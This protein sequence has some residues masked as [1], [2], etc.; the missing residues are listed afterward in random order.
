VK[1][2]NYFV[3]EKRDP[4]IGL[5]DEKCMTIRREGM[6]AVNVSGETCDCSELKFVVFKRRKT[7][8]R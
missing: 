3:D 4:V 8:I 7:E 2:R 1:R 5:T 6:K